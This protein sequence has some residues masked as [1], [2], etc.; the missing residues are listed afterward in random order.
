MEDIP[1]DYPGTLGTDQPELGGAQTAE[2]VK[3]PEEIKDKI[4]T[5]L[6]QMSLLGQREFLKELAGEVFEKAEKNLNNDQA[7]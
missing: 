5:L 7:A 4:R 3:T 6:D 1:G 2:I